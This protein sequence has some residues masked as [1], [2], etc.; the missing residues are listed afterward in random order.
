MNTILY[1]TYFAISILFYS[2]GKT[3][4]TSYFGGKHFQLNKWTENTECKMN[5]LKIIINQCLQNRILSLSLSLSLLIKTLLFL[6]VW[7]LGKH[8]KHNATSHG[9][10]Q[11][12]TF[13]GDLGIKIINVRYE[14]GCFPPA[15]NI[16]WTKPGWRHER[17]TERCLHTCTAK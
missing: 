6:R 12:L 5:I 11:L 8:L 9:W 7:Y 2:R 4:A 16:T 3:F 13:L 15:V 14:H 17:P 10:H 1:F